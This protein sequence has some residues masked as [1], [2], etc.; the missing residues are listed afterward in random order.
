MCGIGA[1]QGGV[2]RILR[3]P[4]CRLRIWQRGAESCCG[5]GSSNVL[6]GPEVL[7]T[8][9]PDLVTA[10]HVARVESGQSGWCAPEILRAHGEI[11]LKCDSASAP[12]AEAMFHRSLELARQHNALGWELRAAISLASLWKD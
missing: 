1:A 3:Q 4:C 2:P 9:V 11:L 7:A 12:E 5:A 6:A 8:F 10:G